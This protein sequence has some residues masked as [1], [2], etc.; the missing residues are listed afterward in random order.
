MKVETGKVDRDLV[1]QDV[2]RH[3]IYVTLEDGT[4]FQIKEREGG[5]LQVTC[6]TGSMVMRPHVS[7]VVVLAYDEK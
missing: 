5:Q 7:N 1:S 2:S 6:T 3:G 4:E